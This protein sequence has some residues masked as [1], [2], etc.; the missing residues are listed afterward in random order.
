MNKHSIN[1]NRNVSIGESGFGVGES[2][3]IV[4]ILLEELSLNHDFRGNICGRFRSELR[5][6][7]CVAKVVKGE[8]I[9]C[10]I[11]R[12]DRNFDVDGICDVER[13]KCMVV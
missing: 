10:E 6:V 11:V 7:V 8:P 3:H 4:E 9:F 12:E 2:S 13:R 1:R 5:G